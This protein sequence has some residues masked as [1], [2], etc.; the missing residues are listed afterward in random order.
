MSAVFV[1]ASSQSLQ[2][3]APPVTA[4]P[5][6]VGM[7]VY[8]QATGSQTIWSLG[9]SGAVNFW[10]LGIA[11]A[12]NA[13]AIAINGGSATGGAA[14]SNAWQFIVGRLI[15]SGNQRMAALNADGSTTHVALTSA[16]AVTSVNLMTLGIRVDAAQAYTGR[17][18]EF[19]IA[20]VDIQPGGAQLQDALLRQLAYFGPFSVPH[21]ANRVLDYRSLRSRL[22]SA[23]DVPDEI[24]H[25]SVRQVWTNSNAATRGPNPP[26]ESLVEPPAIY[27]PPMVLV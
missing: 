17:V 13:W 26:A 19:W 24:Y 16:I 12:G 9:Q 25:R 5:F 15:A 7:W 4:Y 14:V 3:A 8:P 6:T 23:R 20:D 10:R 22:D 11:A 18:A 21:I 27:T 2:N 1:G